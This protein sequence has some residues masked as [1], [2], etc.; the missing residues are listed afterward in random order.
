MKQPLK[1]LCY[2]TLL[3]SF[4][5]YIHSDAIYAEYWGFSNEPPF[6][7]DEF[8]EKQRLSLIDKINR[9]PMKWEDSEK[10]DRGTV[11]NEI[12]D[13]MILGRNSKKMKIEKVYETR[14]YGQVDNCD[15]SERWA[16]VEHTNKVIAL[17][18]EYNK[19]V[20]EFPI[21]ICREFSDYF[22]GAIPQVRAEGILPTKYGDVMVYGDIDELMPTSVHDIKT[23]GKYSPGK[24][25]SHWQHVVYPYC[26]CQ[27][28]NKVYDFEYN[29]LTIHE[30]KYSKSY[31]TF[32]EYYN[33]VPEVDIP[34]LTAHVE[35]LIEFIESHRDLITDLKIFNKHEK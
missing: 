13:C 31:E 14:V 23:T 29:I 34:R 4:Q 19:R 5:G 6:S 25:K 12:V 2:A 28:G 30:T 20:F 10:A 32:T 22:K 15:A 1:Y 8:H 17:K 35:G 24:F 3:D 7:E 11:F 16:D 27:A 33:Y 9:V 18:A 26:L 21:D